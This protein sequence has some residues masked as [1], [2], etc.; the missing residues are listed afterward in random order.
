MKKFQIV[1]FLLSIFLLSGCATY[2]QKNEKFQ[3]YIQSGQIEKADN[4][5]D[6]KEKDKNDKNKLLYY[7]NS[8]WVNW[9]LKNNDVS[10][11]AFQEADHMMEDYRKNYGLEAL[12]L[13][14]NPNVKPYKP[15]D[16]EK[17]FVNYFKALNYIALGQY[18]EALVECRRMNIILN[19][20]NDK[21]KDHK[22]RYQ[23]DAFAHLV[24]GLIYEA[25]GQWNDAFIAYRNALEIYQNEYKSEFNVNVPQQL[26]LDLI[27][28]AYKTGF[29]E[30][31]RKYE[32]EFGVTHQPESP[33]GGELVLIWQNGF[34]PVKSEWSVNFTTVDKGGGWVS[35]VNDEYGFSFPY[36]IGDKSKEDQS[37]FSQL[38]FLRVAFPKYLERKPV[39]TSASVIANQTDYP[40]ELAEN[41]NAIAFKTLHDRMLREFGNSLLRLAAK[42]TIELSTRK[43][44]Q[45]I[46]AAVGIINALTEKADT[47]NW[48]TLPYE[49]CYTRVPLNKG[50][51]QI[52]LKVSNNRNSKSYDFTF[53][54]LNGNLQFFTFQSVETYPPES[55]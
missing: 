16:F 34:G 42:K 18:N 48:Q 40:L 10:N 13:I 15:E 51:N 52:K 36:F 2:Y 44:N 23:R 55:R 32:K 53:D 9:M 12:A 30:E 26:K 21:Y 43:E 11:Q 39:F 6:K 19:E 38:S 3:E 24:M 8:G 29:T 47:R 28:A 54:G 17:V 46:G 14:T 49:I 35:F 7:L 1:F 33:E 27:N 22:N 4:Y 31:G 25:N 5:L 45:D 20:L 41:V 37:A 50:E